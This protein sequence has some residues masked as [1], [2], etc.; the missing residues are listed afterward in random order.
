ME[1]K[2]RLFPYPVLCSDTDDYVEGGFYAD[3]EIVE[4]GINA[5]QLHF[6]LHLN[7][8]EIKNLISRG[9][10]EFVVHIECS[11]TAFRTTINSFTGDID[12]KI[13]SSKVNGPVALLA[14]VVAKENIPHY[15]N[16]ALN[17]DYKDIALILEKGSILA[18]YNMQPLIVRKNY[19]ELVHKDSIFSIVKNSSLHAFEQEPVSFNIENQRIQILV[20]EE[21]YNLFTRYQDNEKMKSM[22]IVLFVMPA[23]TYMVE[24]L[25][26]AREEDD[27]Y[28][29]Y[30]WFET[31]SNHFEAQGKDFMDVITDDNNRIAMLVQ[32]MLKYPIDSAV[33][34]IPVM[35]GEE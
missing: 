16:S 23:L 28:E 25:R 6:D 13:M 14:L 29:K 4:E 9:K 18:Y 27:H 33:M 11:N 5:I 17:E 2:N 24:E 3:T 15:R 10:A 1:I 19:E 30:L 26:N 31:L 7:N 21:V 8:A 35:L 34:N 32:E 12:C 22:M 20:R